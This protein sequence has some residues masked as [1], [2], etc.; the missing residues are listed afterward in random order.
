MYG[1]KNAIAEI[2]SRKAK[3]SI[4]DLEFSYIIF[5]F[6]KIKK[7]YEVEYEMMMMFLYLNELKY[8]K[9]EIE[10]NKH[11]NLKDLLLLKYI[12]QYSRIE[13]IVVF[14]L[15]L[16]ALKIIEHFNKILKEKKFISKNRLFLEEKPEENAIFDSALDDYFD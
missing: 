15:S 2:Y 9:L 4:G 14:R 1:K 13:G 5:A 6:E 12:E 11:I 3:L 8:F 7:K 16:S 10:T